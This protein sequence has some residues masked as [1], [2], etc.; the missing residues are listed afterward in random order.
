[1]SIKSGNNPSIDLTSIFSPSSKAL[2][3]M[4]GNPFIS[5]KNPTGDM[6]AQSAI[7]GGLMAGG[8]GNA[9]QASGLPGMMPRL[10]LNRRGGLNPQFDPQTSMRPSMMGGNSFLP[11]QF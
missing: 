11:F 10:G 9:T 7:A 1:M 5:G 2:A 3:S 4:S 6:P 8:A